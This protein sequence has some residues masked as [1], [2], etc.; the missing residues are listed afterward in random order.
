L[1]KKRNEMSN[2]KNDILEEA[3]DEPIE[4]IVI[5]EMG[6]GGDY[7]AEGKPA[8]DEVRGKIL[9]WEEAS[10]YLDYEYDDGYGATGCQAIAAWTK[11]RVL[12]VSQYD[13]ST[14]V[15]SVYRNPTEHNPN[16]P[17]G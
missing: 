16:M 9:T 14:T 15:E 11:T 10:P 4:A 3:G 6:W 7:N 12:F 17:G 5:G 8:W 2:F 13:G 1:W